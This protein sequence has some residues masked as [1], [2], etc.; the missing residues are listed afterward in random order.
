MLTQIRERA[1]GWLAW[2]IV[3]LITIPFALWGIQSY[4]GNPADIPVATVNG[5]EIPLYAYYNE[6]SRRRQAL[7][8]QTG[9]NIDPAVLESPEMRNEVVQSMILTRL[10]VQYVH[11]RDYRLSDQRLKR[12]IQ[13][14]PIFLND[15]RF[16]PGLYR[17]L[18]RNSGYSIQSYESQ[19]RDSAT[20]DQL[21]AALIDSSF[22]TESEINR[23]LSLQAQ[24]RKTDYVIVPAER[25]ASESGVSDEEA[26][27]Y[28]QDNLAEFEQPARARVDYIELGIDNLARAV[29]PTDAEISEVY[30]QTSGRYRQ[31]ETRKVS[32]ILFAVEPDAGDRE[33]ADILAVAEGVL[34]EAQSGADF[35]ELAKTH[36]D[37]PGSKGR[38]GDLGVVAR[39]QMVEPF[40]VAVFDMTEDEIRGPV[41]TR[42]GYHI[43]R[44][45]ELQE[46][47]QKPLEEVREEVAEEAG[48]A[49]AEA[50]FVELSETFENL[51][52]E[53][54]DSL[55]TAAAELGLEIR[56]TGWFTEQGGGQE[57]EEDGGLTDQIQFRRA[58]FSEDVLNNDLNSA[59]LALGF[60]RLVALRKND[61]QE[62][63]T[64]TFDEVRD[65]IKERL[66]Q[67][68]SA[69]KAGEL[70]DKLVTDLS[71]GEFDWAQMLE[72]QQLESQTLAEVRDL[73]PESLAKLGDA[74]FSQA[75]PEP[76]AAAYGGVFLDNG[77]YAVYAL[78]EVVPGELENI[79]DTQRLLLRDQLLARDGD[80]VYRQMLQ[81]IR[82]AAAVVIDRELVRDPDSVLEYGL[83]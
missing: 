49:Q 81:T 82:Q 9:G 66:Q 72:D 14:N 15:G 41:E 44:L 80:Y 38:G 28:Y 39:G 30:E 20:V 33:R 64:R 71:G 56:R 18:L 74:V 23:L 61:Y 4:F 40:E 25:F 43:I 59:A 45:T 12:R 75:A 83:Q 57:S 37:D 60:D 31:P 68:Q 16:D 29:E 17:D 8:S 10:L 7:L 63:R 50:L 5:E 67:Q 54:P 73:V 77:D 46:E 52:F 51:V 55:T 42:F 35:A 6:L 3:I 48:R 34:A 1:T 13:S 70:G 24:T 78:N 36:S 26:Q 47:R 22:V 69:Q 19:E 32:H 65:D 53:N 11:E 62:A 27:Q 76:E 58:A 21:N 79:D 2:V